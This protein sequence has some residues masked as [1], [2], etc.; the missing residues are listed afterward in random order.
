[1]TLAKIALAAL[2]K[3]PWKNGGGVSTDIAVEPEGAGWDASLW[4]VAIAEI[5]ASGPFSHFSGYDR[6]FMALG[7]GVS[8]TIDG[9]QRVAASFEVVPFAGDATTECRL[10]PAAGKGPVQAFNLILRRGAAGGS[11]AC[12]AGAVRLAAP[13]QGALVLYTA[14][15]GFTVVEGDGRPVRLDAGEALVHRGGTPL[16]A[17]PYKPWALL[18]SAAVAPETV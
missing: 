17:E 5:A 1:M 18:V 6:Q 3:Q 10:D 2:P 11:V 4:R 9:Q 14:R 13:P 15:G 8:L 12:H 16:A 7:P